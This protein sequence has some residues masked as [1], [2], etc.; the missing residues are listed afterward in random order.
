MKKN[1]SLTILLAIALILFAFAL[2]VYRPAQNNLTRVTV[3]G[4]SQSKVAPDSAVVTFSVVT[5]N[6]QAVNAQQENARKSEAVKKAVE[7]I[8]ADAEIKTSDYNLQPEQDYTSGRMPKIIGYEAK[9]SVTVSISNLNQTGALIDAA[10]KAGANSVEG[11]SFVLRENSPARGDALTLA[12]RQAMIKAESIAQ[13]L[14][15]KIV[16]VVET[17]EGGIAPRTPVSDYS[18]ASMSNSMTVAAK[19]SYITPVEAGSLDVRSQVLLVV[20]IE[21]KR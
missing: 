3:L 9:N 11:I 18:N 1:V 4:E 21:V 14:G 13:S 6:A 2:Y 20:E 10:T 8:N 12:T 17:S 15:G 7:A 16:R 5:Q 19:R